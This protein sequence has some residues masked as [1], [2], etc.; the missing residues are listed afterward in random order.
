MNEPYLKRN[1][2]L[3]DWSPD[4]EIRFRKESIFWFSALGDNC[5]EVHHVG[6]TSIR[7]I[8]AKPIVDV[9]IVVGCHEKLDEIHLE[10]YEA[11]GENG[12]K[13]RRYFQKDENGERVCHIHVYE[14]G[15]KNI[16]SHLYFKKM[17]I[18]YPE[19][20]GEYERL[21]ESLAQRFK[22][23]KAAYTSA[24]SS[25]ICKVLSSV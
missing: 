5:L 1:V 15:H 25:F 18:T 7:G 8:K 22:E 24:K 4:W 11:K 9:L 3:V 21:K 16:I 2:R 19:L 10:G 6:S 20:A 23:N 14:K 12:I 17:L 13:G